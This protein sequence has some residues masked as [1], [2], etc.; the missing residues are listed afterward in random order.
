MSNITDF[1]EYT[2]NLEKTVKNLVTG[3][4]DHAI[5][6]T[7]DENDIVNVYSTADDELTDEM[8]IAALGGEIT[9]QLED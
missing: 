5:I 7:I 3:N 9:L 2:V 4:I 1:P 8:L 6:L